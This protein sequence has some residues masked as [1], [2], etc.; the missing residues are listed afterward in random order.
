METKKKCFK[1]FEIKNIEEFNKN[2]SKKDGVNGICKLCHSDYRRNHYLN[3]KEKVLNQVNEYRINNSEKIS[4]PIKKTIN[5]YS[6]KAGRTIE[7]KCEKCDNIVYQSKEQINS[8][9]KKYCSI[10]CRKIDNKSDYHYYLQQIK[11]R[12]EK[13]KKNFDLD[14]VFL[15][16]LL[17]ITQKNKCNITNI[18]I[19]MYHRNELKSIYNTASLDRIDSKGGYTK[20]NVQWVCLGI[21]YMKM[22]FSNK[23]L[24]DLLGLIKE[25]YK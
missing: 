20:D 3:N 6:K 16:E 2:K 10:E 9:Q 19:K 5:S 15:K 11:K 1:C 12:A 17:E 7:V 21:N 23:D 14:E 25:N 18:R 22:D 4:E 24:H 8:N 13:I